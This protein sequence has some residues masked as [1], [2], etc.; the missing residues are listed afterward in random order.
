M[1]LQDEN[2]EKKNIFKKFNKYGERFLSLALI[3]FC[4]YFA[5]GSQKID[6]HKLNLMQKNIP[7]AFEYFKEYEKITKSPFL[8]KGG[9][10]ISSSIFLLH[11]L[12]VN[13][14]IQFVKNSFPVNLQIKKV[15]LILSKIS[16]KKLNSIDFLKIR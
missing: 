3:T 10:I 9:E 16:Y 4:D 7:L 13:L 14:L 11:H 2:F 15:P 12:S 6:R 8:I 1:I 5:K